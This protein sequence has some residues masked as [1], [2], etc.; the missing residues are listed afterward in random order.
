VRGQRFKS[1]ILEVRYHGKNVHDV[2]EMTVREALAFFVNVRKLFQSCGVLNEMGLAICG[3]G[4]RP[5]LCLAGRRSGLK[6]AAHLTRS[7]IKASFI[8]STKPTTGLHFDDI[9]KL[10]GAFR[11][12]LS[13][14]ASLLVIEHNL[15]VIKSATGLI[16]IGAGGRRPGWGR[17]L[18]RVRRSRWR[19]MPQFAH[20]AVSGESACEWKMARRSAPATTALRRGWHG[21]RA[22]RKRQSNFAEP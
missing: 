20:R 16:D 11:R 19:A 3:W 9:A 21:G 8:F 12:L 13:L 10:L 7:R 6:L 18:L 5:R 4:S 14:G 22:R 2:L 1:S 17:S 15:D